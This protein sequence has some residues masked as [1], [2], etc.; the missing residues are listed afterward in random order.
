MD[1]D[2]LL[3]AMEDE[4]ERNRS[5]LFEFRLTLGTDCRVQRFGLRL[6]YSTPASTLVRIY[7]VPHNSMWAT[8]WSRRY[9]V[10]AIAKWRP[11]A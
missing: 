10:P 1:D 6:A 7:Y 5:H 8:N 9:V 3:A 2:V 11:N 4:Q